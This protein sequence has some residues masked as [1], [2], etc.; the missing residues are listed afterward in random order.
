METEKRLAEYVAET[1]FQD[2]PEEP[3]GVIKNVVL[4]ILG[5]AIAGADAEG[6]REVVE[7]ARRWGG[8]REATLLIHGGKVG[9]HNAAFANSVMARALD[10]DDVMNPGIHI[11]ASSVPTAL[12][13]AELAGG[14]S[15]KDFLAALVLGT[16]VGARINGASVYDG[17][18]PVGVCTIFASTAVAG[19]ILGLNSKQ[20]L[21]ALALAFNKAGGSFQSN[22]DGSLAVRMI[23]GFASQGGVIS[24][25]LAQRGITGP[26]NFLEGIHG[27]FHLYA[28]DRRDTEM[29]AGG[30][31][32]RFELAGT[33]FKKYPSSGSTLAG[34]HAALDLVRE[35]GIGPED[36]AEVTVKV[37]PYVY[38]LGGHRF[39]IGDNPTV[40]AQFNIQ[41]CVANAFLRK[42]S[43]LHHFEPSCVKDPRVMDL[44]RRVHTQPDAALEGRGLMAMDMEVV[45]KDG[46]V[47]HRSV[48]VPPG[49]PDNPLSKDEHME[50]FWD[51]V[52]FTSRPWPRD[53][54][55]KIISLIGE[56]EGVEDVRG[57]IPLL[58]SPRSSGRSLQRS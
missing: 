26:Q 3:V 53:D 51:C 12:A 19:K 33:I 2:L 46:T 43:K 30:L 55:D 1:R 8:R 7:L 16:E 57:L 48:D 44:A 18:D 9:A 52:G 50:R 37:T 6:C 35:K 32:E 5:T 11:G 24:A 38:K 13:V 15:G 36:V 47:F 25:Q 42:S 40:N 28:K 31:G 22:I 41:Y 27:Y 21:D 49:L 29:V 23:Q 14:C 54:V 39:E 34:T 58:L 17:F 4:T 56:L 45:T 10:F 20:M